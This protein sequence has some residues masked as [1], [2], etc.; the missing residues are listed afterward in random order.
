MLIWVVF[1]VLTTPLCI[2]AAWSDLKF[3]KIPNILSILLGLVFVVSGIF[4]L[5]LDEYLWRLLIGVAAVLVG[6]L[7][8]LSGL[9]GG[10]DIKLFAAM[11]PFI[12]PNELY[13]FTFLVSITALSGVAAHRVVGKLGLA[14]AGWKSWE[15]GK[16]YPLGLSLAGALIFYF[17]IHIGKAIA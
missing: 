14:P 4:L 12:T 10:G 1:L 7:I 17:L 16:K 9:I 13:A 3:L 11:L 5:P 15:G 2:W 8:Y 6:F